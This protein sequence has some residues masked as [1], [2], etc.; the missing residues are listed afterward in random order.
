[1]SVE[2]G[3]H[4]ASGQAKRIWR[5]AKFVWPFTRSRAVLSLGLLFAA[6]LTEGFSILL[7]IPILAGLMPGATEVDISISS[8]LPGISDIPDIQ[9]GL[10]PLLSLLVIAVALQGALARLSNIAIVDTTLNAA[11]LM[12]TQLFETVGYAR[13]Q[14]IMMGR[15]ADIT[16]VMTMDVD[17]VHVVLSCLLFSV[18]AIVMLTLYIALA[19]F[20]S[21]TM[22]AAAVIFGGLFVIF[23]HPLRTFASRYGER[24]SKQRQA[25]YR[26]IGEFLNGLKVVKSLNAED[27]YVEAFT[28]NSSQITGDLKRLARVKALPP[29]LFQIFSAV[30]AAAFIYGA[31]VFVKLPIEQIAVLLFL[32]MKIAPRFANLQSDYQEIIINVGGYDNV[33]AVIAGY[34]NDQD[35][36]SATEDGKLGLRNEIAFDDVTFRYNADTA[37]VLDGVNFVVPA[38]QITALIGASGSG[39]STVADLMMGLLEP[40]EGSIRIDGADLTSTLGRAW[41]SGVAYVPQDA[42]LA[43]DTVRANLLFARPDASEAQMW[44]A[45]DQAQ[46]GDLVRKLTAGLET[47]VGE[48]GLRLSGGE[49]QRIAL[50]RA[51]LTTPEVLI[52][53]EA[54]SALDWQNQ[55]L[56]AHAI[57][58]LRG[59]MTV[60]TIAHRP[61]MIGFA[62]WVVAIV[63]GKVVETGPFSAFAANEDSQLSRLIAGENASTQ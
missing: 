4:S 39:K 30:G 15:H 8:M 19:L 59:T 14:A 24:L 10:L 27:R 36:P 25:Q 31:V 2:T 26:T 57:E 63:D 62:D 44:H 23:L 6:G 58:S 43:N 52:L 33:A 16:H 3:I 21:P 13:W 41:R 61:S 47:E 5:V 34:R 28:G 56:I 40:T 12:R 18:Q 9:I 11:H 42:Y 46:A 45:L 48:D 35:V 20:V 60:I 17:R 38:R 50:A 1:M 49:R 32:F 51:L 37:P 55:A 54:T 53:D 22:T 29:Y 7:V